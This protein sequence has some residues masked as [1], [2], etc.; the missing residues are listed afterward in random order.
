MDKVG[1]GNIVD[2]GKST[3]AKLDASVPPRDADQNVPHLHGAKHV[4][5]SLPRASLSVVI[6]IVQR[7]QAVSQ[8]VVGGLAHLFRAEDSGCAV[9]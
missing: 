1:P 5:Q 4:K 2:N 3:W 7:I 6:I 9:T 8:D